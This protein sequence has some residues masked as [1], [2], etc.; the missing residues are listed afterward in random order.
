MFPFAVLD[1]AQKF[2][3]FVGRPRQGAVNVFRDGF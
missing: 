3:A 2:G 1:H